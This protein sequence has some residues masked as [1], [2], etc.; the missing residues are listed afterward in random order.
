MSKF[1]IVFKRE[2]AQV[3][4]K[5]S[6]VVGLILMPVLMLAF[7]LLPALLAHMK[8]DGT[9]RLAIIDQTERSIGNQ[10]AESLNEYKLTDDEDTPYYSVEQVYTIDPGD[11]ARFR[12]VEDSLREQINDKNIKYF[13]VLKQD[14]DLVD[15]SMYIVTNSDNFRSLRRFERKLSNLM[16]SVRLEMSDINLSVDSA[17][18][19][20]RSIDLVVRDTKGE[21]MPFLTKYFSALVFVM[22]LFGTIL[23]Y[24]QLV[25]RSVIEEK[26]SRI[27]EVMI[28]SVSPFQLMMGKVIGLGAATMTQVAVWFAMG[29]GLFLLRSSFDIDP[30]IDRIVFNPVIIVF[31]VLYLVSG[32]LL[33]ST[34]FALL[35]SIVTSD[36]EAQSLVAPITMLLILPVILGIAV[37]QEPNSLMARVLSLIPFTAPT[38]MMMRLVFVAPTLSE[39]SLFSG[40]VGEALLGFLLVVAAFAG[41]VW[42]TSKVFRIGILMYGKRPTL[43][44]IIKWL[45][46]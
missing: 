8:A 25:M 34:L 43:P 16:A 2:Y 21:S 23:G 24:G 37:V 19:L 9:E 7:V 13:L 28:S 17:L 41:M 30:S 6:F 36:K 46:Y 35:G 3:V 12:A 15:S 45:K 29:A 5:K 26:N 27:M 40:I 38:M 42:L 32:Y 39:Y 4:K 1:L 10:F 18:S 20:T 31:F 11:F 14:A 33:F 22:V 44:E